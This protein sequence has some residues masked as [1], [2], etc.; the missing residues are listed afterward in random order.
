MEE[1]VS[2]VHARAANVARASYGRL[3]ALLIAKNRDIPAAE[4]ALADAFERALT[5]WSVS[6]I[7]ENPEAW[8]LTVARNRQIDRQRSMAYRTSVSLDELLNDADLNHAVNVG[9]IEDKR[10]A[11]MFVCAH[12]AIEVNIRTPLMLQT[13]LGFRTEEIA[14]SLAIPTPALTQRLVRAK[15]RIRGAGI[16]F[17]VPEQSEMAGRLP[18]VLEAVYGTFAI[19]WRGVGGATERESLTWEAL[20]LAE[21]LANLLSR[22]PETLGLAALVCFSLARAPARLDVSGSLIPLP[23]QDVARWNDSLI[24][25][26][27]DHLSRAHQFEKIGRFQIEAAIQAVHCSRKRSG[28]TDW[29]TLSKLHLALIDC[30]PTLGAVVSFAVVTGEIEGPSAGLA[31]LDSMDSLKSQRFQPAWAARAYLLEK[32]GRTQE[33]VSAFEKAISITTDP[34]ERNYLKKQVSK[35]GESEVLN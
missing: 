15:R 10:L 23:L 13:V 35:L 12:P 16:P 21:T 22:E 14:R 2:L 3:L 28:K 25:R 11:L 1:L 4:D 18:A 17:F 8:L 29:A 31:I 9:L 24:A 27:E 20:Y 19:D 33:A 32:M 5:T 6:G 7:P 26:G 34:V 30:A